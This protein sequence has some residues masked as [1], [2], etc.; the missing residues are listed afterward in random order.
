MA[1]CVA[2]TEFQRPAVCRTL[3]AVVVM[4]QPENLCLVFFCT[5]PNQIAFLQQ[6]NFWTTD[7]AYENPTKFG[8]A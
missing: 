6:I 2:P 3:R 5:N 7:W 8:W 4:N 1:I